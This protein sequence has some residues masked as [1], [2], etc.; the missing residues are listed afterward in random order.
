MVYCD[1]L[2]VGLGLVLGFSC[3]SGCLVLLGWYNTDL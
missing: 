3:F 2:I 1:V